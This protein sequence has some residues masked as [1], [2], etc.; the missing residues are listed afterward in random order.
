MKEGVR[1]VDEVGVIERD[2]V[3]EDDLEGRRVGDG[4]RVEE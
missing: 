2:R 3:G 1:V 4:V